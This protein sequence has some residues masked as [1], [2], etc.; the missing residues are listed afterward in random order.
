M[1]RIFATTGITA[2]LVAA[3]ALPGTASAK[4]HGSLLFTYTA[5]IDCG[6]GEVTVLS[7]DDLYAPL[8]DAASG[9]TYQPV[10]WDVVYDGQRIEDTRPGRLPKA[11]HLVDCAYDDGGAAGTVTVVAPHGT[12]TRADSAGLH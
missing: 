12:L 9:R 6:A 11:K 5:T 1:K 8:F 2:A 7:T 10:A 3:L 4:R